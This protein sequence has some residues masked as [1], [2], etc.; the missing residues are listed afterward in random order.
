M[1][2]EKFAHSI[3]I[4]YQNE[5]N[6]Q[7]LFVS[8]LENDIKNYVLST[9]RNNDIFKNSKQ[10]NKNKVYYLPEKFLFSSPVTLFEG[11]ESSGKT[12]FMESICKRISN[13]EIKLSYI[14]KV[15][16][17][18]LLNY[19]PHSS[20]DVLFNSFVSD[21]LDILD[22]NSNAKKYLL[23]YLSIIPD[24]TNSNKSNF[25]LDLISKINKEINKPILFIIDNI[26]KISSNV[27]ILLRAINK[28][29]IVSNFVFLFIVNYEYKVV[30]N[31]HKEL[32]AF[33][34]LPIY[35]FSQDYTCVLNKYGLN[36]ELIDKLNIVFKENDES[37]IDLKSLDSFLT[38]NL[39]SNGQMNKYKLLCSIKTLS[40]NTSHN[41]CNIYDIIHENVDLFYKGLEELKGLKDYRLKISKDFIMDHLSLS[42]LSCN[43]EQEDNAYDSQREYSEY[44]IGS[45]V[46]Y[47][48]E[49]DFNNIYDNQ[50]KFDKWS[51]YKNELIKIQTKVISKISHI[52]DEI[53]NIE[54]EI[55]NKKILK[56][57]K[58]KINKDEIFSITNVKVSSG[59][60][61]IQNPENLA[62]ELTNGTPDQIRET[63][64]KLNSLKEILKKL[65]IIKNNFET[66]LNNI[67][68][69][70]NTLPGRV[71]YMLENKNFKDDIIEFDRF[72]KNKPKNVDDTDKCIKSL[73]K[74]KSFKEILET[75]NLSELENVIEFVRYNL[76]DC[77]M[78]Y[79]DNLD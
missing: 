62:D 15:R 37:S 46:K 47:E 26:E 18:N 66:Y 60:L 39:L 17:I 48:L 44:W 23:K 13:N 69:N 50:D 9:S 58:N 67:V 30:S 56:F 38:S 12:T 11:Y 43:H 55:S 76:A 14:N 1:L 52:E 74:F 29:S 21:L 70:T 61:E 35:R 68:D 19:V 71:K 57:K 75:N 8:T 27:E 65:N 10:A 73:F 63:R 59:N 72:L 78:E 16:T 53:S 36:S 64:D 20:G 31:I 22:K 79:Y 51:K 42:E 45:D 25:D 6:E 28:L 49:S 41:S 33:V 3:N 32:E 5:Y 54:K 24:K 77:I 7:K 2:R 40:L 4:N 34:N